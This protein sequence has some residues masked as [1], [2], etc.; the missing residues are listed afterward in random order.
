M[1]IKKINSNPKESFGM[2]LKKPDLRGMT[3]LEIDA[4]T[5]SLPELKEIAK[6]IDLKI[7]K[8]VHR[9]A[10]SRGSE[11]DDIFETGKKAFK[12][13]AAYSNYPVYVLYP[14]KANK[15]TIE[16]IKLNLSKGKAK[17]FSEDMRSENLEELKI[18][19]LDAAKKAKE[20]F[21]ENDIGIGKDKLKHAMEKKP[22]NFEVAA[23]RKELKNLIEKS[24][25]S[26]KTFPEHTNPQQ[27]PQ[28]DQTPYGFLNREA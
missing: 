28:K 17:Y 15:S 9:S 23:T 8:G 24:K 11:Y 4:I 21:L 16:R 3:R 25:N 7:A 10:H 19:L 1:Q 6:D 22:I 13:K 27:P 2:A 20:K 14:S 12:K 26:E 5:E 18:I